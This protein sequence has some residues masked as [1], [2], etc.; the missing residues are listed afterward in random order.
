MRR[1]A[2]RRARAIAAKGSISNIKTAMA[3]E[4]TREEALSRKIK[5]EEA[6]AREAAKERDGHPAVKEP[7]AEDTSPKEVQ[8]CTDEIAQLGCASLP[9]GSKCAKF[10]GAEGV[11]AEKRVLADGSMAGPQKGGGNARSYSVHKRT[12]FWVGD[13][14]KDSCAPLHTPATR[15]L[16]LYSPGARGVPLRCVASCTHETAL[17]VL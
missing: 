17:K 15:C 8:G 3:A 4:E 5:V 11:A 1:A 10:C 2:A 13:A 7:A 9:F 16:I 12:G 14:G 6:A